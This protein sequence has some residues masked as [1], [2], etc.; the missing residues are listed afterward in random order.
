MCFNHIGNRR[1]RILVEI[2]VDNYFNSDIT[3]SKVESVAISSKQ[4]DIINSVLS[5]IHGNSPSGRFLLPVG[6]SLTH[7]IDNKE[8]SCSFMFWKVASNEEV[9]KKVHITFLAA[10]RFFIKKDH[11]F[12]MTEKRGSSQVDVDDEDDI[13]SNDDAVMPESGERLSEDK[14]VLLERKAQAGVEGTKESNV[15]AV[16]RLSRVRVGAGGTSVQSKVRRAS[17]HDGGADERSTFTLNLEQPTSFSRI[18]HSGINQQLCLTNGLANTHYIANMV[19]TFQSIPMEEFFMPDARDSTS[20]RVE[21]IP[22]P[23]AFIMPSNY[24][25]LCGS[26]QAFFHHIGNRRFRIVVEMNIQRYEK[27]YRKVERGEICEIHELVAEINQSIA[28]CEPQGRFLAMDM[29]TGWWRVLSPMYSQL[30]IEQT[31]LQCMQVKQREYQLAAAIEAATS[32]YGVKVKDGNYKPK[33]N[34]KTSSLEERQDKSSIFFPSVFGDKRELMKAQE[35]AKIALQKKTGSIVTNSF[36]MSMIDCNTNERD[37]LLHADDK[38]P[39]SSAKDGNYKPKRNKKTSS[40]EERQDKS[41]IFFPSVFGDKRELMKAQE[42]A[43]IA[44]QKK[45]GSIVTNSFKMSM[46][47]CNTN[48]RDDLLHADDKKPQSSADNSILA[49]VSGMITLS[50]RSS[51]ST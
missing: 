5:S 50:R 31:L 6:K 49:A 37:D 33:R 41:S 29:N 7:C 2:N 45:T 3:L 11:I 39:Q 32:L 51:S 35:Y 18:L 43:K 42:Y 17:Q 16:E 26:G 47:D 21:L 15:D 44:L 14:N 24:D 8:D 40:L 46:I 48:E 22:H 36:K 27:E 13:Q 30:K 19:K 38:K 20:S 12:D 25:V 10:G 1:F 34:K 23:A 28:S 9:R 4:D